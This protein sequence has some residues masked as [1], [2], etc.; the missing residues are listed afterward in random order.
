VSACFLLTRYE[1]EGQTDLEGR[2]ELRQGN[3]EKVEVEEEFELFIEYDGEECESVV[4]LVADSVWGKA[5]LQFFWGTEPVRSRLANLDWTA[6]ISQ[7]VMLS[8][9]T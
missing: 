6:E 7:L 4:L 9:V 5:G 2:Y 8:R 1:L 3:E